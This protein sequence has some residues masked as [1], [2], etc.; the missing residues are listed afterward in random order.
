MMRPAN[1]T[2]VCAAFGWLAATAACAGVRDEFAYSLPVEVP[3]GKPVVRVD[4]PLAVYRDCVDPAL[5]DLRVLNGAGEVVPYAL[6]RPVSARDAAPTMQR[7]PLFP[8]RGEAAVPGAALQLRIEAGKTSIE[9]EGAPPG[10]LASPVAAPIS[11]YL[12]NASAVDSAIGSFTFGWPEE[13]EDFAVNLVISASDDL[14]NWR[15]VA[16]RAP[17]ARLRHAGDVFEQRSVSFPATRAQFWRVSPEPSGQLPEITAVDATLVTASVPVARLQIEVDG[18]AVTGQSDLYDFDLGAELPVD[19]VELVLPQLNTVAHAELLAREGAT[20]DWRT[21]NS[22]NMYR[23]QSANGELLSPPV[24]IATVPARHWRIKVD[25]RGGG[26][27]RGIPRLRVGWLADQLLFVARGPGPFEIV[28]GSAE[29]RGAAVPLDT[30]LPGDAT[31]ASMTG[32]E[33][34]LAATGAAHEAGGPSL[35]LPPPPTAPWR[36][37][38]LWAALIAGV[39]VLAVVAF[40]LARQLRLNAPN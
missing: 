29:A 6:R 4:V 5:R 9:V 24:E 1:F 32:V 14:V 20:A 30:L 26:I 37:W 28:F 27:G 36:T 17:L 3:P 25:P 10:A 40:N 38:I 7:L 39:A 2:W 35:L 33:I 23:L 12:V 21:L 18:A 19:R 11:A 15:D 16:R 13:T 22:L 8:L 34:P 31:F